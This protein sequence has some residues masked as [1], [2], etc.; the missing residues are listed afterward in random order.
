[1][2][3]AQ[4]LRRAGLEVS[5]YASE[6]R[7]ASAEWRVR[8]V[9]GRSPSRAINLI[10]FAFA[11]PIAARHEGADLVLSFARTVGADVLR[12]GGGA[13]A[14]YVRAAQQ[15][16]SRVSAA[17]MW[18]SPYHR[19][20]MFIERR[21]MT[22]PGLKRVIAVS[23]LVRGDIIREFNLPQDKAVTLYNGVDLD[24]FIPA[25]ESAKRGEI[26]LK[27]GIEP[28]VPIALFVGNGFARKGLGFLIDAWPRL[29]TAASLMV[30]GNDR[31][32]AA[33]RQRASALGIERRVFFM[34][35][36]SRVESIFH[37]ADVFALP[38]LFEPFGNAALEAM[39]SGLPVLV[40]S[41]CGVVE[42][43]PDTMKRF[44][45]S[46]PADPDEIGSKLD[47][48][49]EIRIEVARTARPA[50]E[51]FTWER[52]ARGFLGILDGIA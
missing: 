43:L 19:A 17:A 7:A 5:I 31:A 48:L 12:S 50:A 20:Q 4:C 16:R 41:R 34:G 9:G 45:V 24:R 11:S 8:Q 49:I 35:A 47:A 14:S 38:S 25:G 22:H 1:M 13:H 36:Q 26:R 44:V 46:N 2:V 6:M 29:K 32:A 28:S 40:S 27:L 18:V 3:T 10:R 51:Q 42:I 52:Y 37:A 21:A 33:Y 30:V 15:W 39:A 23:E